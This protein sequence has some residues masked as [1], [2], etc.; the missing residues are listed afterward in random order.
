MPASTSTYAFNVRNVLKF[1]EEFH[2][3]K[4]CLI[5]NNSSNSFKDREAHAQRL[6][7]LPRH[8]SI[9]SGMGILI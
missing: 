9:L 1:G 2:E 6:T 7:I 3:D 5:A 8:S 4:S